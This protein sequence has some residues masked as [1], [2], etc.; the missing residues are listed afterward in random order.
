MTLCTA[1]Y[2]IGAMRRI[3]VLVAVASLSA[4]A[5]ASAASSPS[6]RANVP[7]PQAG[8]AGFALVTVRTRA[9]LRSKGPRRLAVT[10]ANEAR[11]PDGVRAA[12]GVLK[13]RVK[14]RLITFKV[15]TAINHLQF[16][17]SL[18]A[19]L[20]DESLTAVFRSANGGMDYDQ[21]SVAAMI[22]Y[23]VGDE[24]ECPFLSLPVFNTAAWVPL[25]P[26]TTQPTPPKQVFLNT[27]RTLC[28]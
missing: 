25:R 21:L 23:G 8:E 20:V 3:A 18:Q 12:A 24:Q 9:K 7:L 19:R 5:Q 6:A 26:P 22:L 13:P 1:R 27:F 4:L 28:P 15:L 16:A 17:R 14:G 10:A 2:R 11:L